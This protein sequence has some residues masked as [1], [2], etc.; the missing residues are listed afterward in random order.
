MEV[1]QKCHGSAVEVPFKYHLSAI[2]VQTAN[3]QEPQP[4]TYAC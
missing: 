2:G 1:A 3:S 4:E